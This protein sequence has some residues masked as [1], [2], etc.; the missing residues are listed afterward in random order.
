MGTYHTHTHRDTL[1]TLTIHRNKMKYRYYS[2]SPTI[3]EILSM[4]TIYEKPSVMLG[5]QAI[6]QLF[7]FFKG[8]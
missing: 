4:T 1:T 2:M 5:M 7:V 6:V 8:W 3:I